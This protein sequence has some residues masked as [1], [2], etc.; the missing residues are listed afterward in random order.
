MHCGWKLSCKDGWLVVLKCSTAVFICNAL[1]KKKILKQNCTY[2][3]MAY[4]LVVAFI[5]SGFSIK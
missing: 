3:D 2:I 1:K 5:P 4:I